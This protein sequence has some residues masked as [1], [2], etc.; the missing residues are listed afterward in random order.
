MPNHNHAYNNNDS[1]RAA[2]IGQDTP[3]TQHSAAENLA[4]LTAD[5]KESN[6]NK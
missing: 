5:R 6:W 4:S 3:V 2:S 1:D